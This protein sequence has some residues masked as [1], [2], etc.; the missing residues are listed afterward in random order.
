[1]KSIVFIALV[2]CVAFQAKAQRIGIDFLLM[3]QTSFYSYG[4]SDISQRYSPS[5][6]ATGLVLKIKV[7]P[8][9]Q[10]EQYCTYSHEG[11]RFNLPEAIS[12]TGT[13]AYVKIGLTNNYIIPLNQ[14]KTVCISLGLGPQIGI[15]TQS[16]IN[17]KS[18]DK[19]IDF[20]SQST[21]T[22]VGAIAHISGDFTISDTNLRTGLR[23]ERGF[24]PISKN[25]AENVYNNTIGFFI[26]IGGWI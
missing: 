24:I 18:T 14:S 10:I 1:M 3:P 22:D 4:S 7:L 23:Y 19:I 15:L 11:H 9:Y 2:I 12:F 8:K 17:M 13:N 21:K 6:L 26:S 25:S 20:Y 5:G 16:N